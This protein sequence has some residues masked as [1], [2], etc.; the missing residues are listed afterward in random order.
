MESVCIIGGGKRLARLSDWLDQPD[1]FEAVTAFLR[2]RG[3]IRSTRVLLAV[4]AASSVLAP[5][6][7]IVPGARHVTVGSAVVIGVV[8]ASLSCVMTWFWLTR[9]PTRRQSLIAASMATVCIVAWSLAQPSAALAALT[10]AAVP[11]TSGYIAFFHSTR[12]L[13]LN[14]AA[15]QVASAV[16]AY[17]LATDVDIKTAIAALWLLWLI[18]MVAPFTVRGLSEAMSKYATRA[19]EDPLTGLLNRRG[20][21]D[22]VERLLIGG[23][24]GGQNYLVML[25][26]DLDDFKR[27]NDTYGHAAGD[28]VLLRVADILRKHAPVDAAICRAGGEEFLLAATSRTGD[29]AFT[30]PLCRAIAALAGNVTA[31]IGVTVVHGQD[32]HAAPR[33]ADLVLELIGAADS[34]MYAAKRSGGNRVVIGAR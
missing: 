34:A 13:A 26:V 9:W 22:V 12:A 28:R 30:T 16:A 24:A 27:I 33:P 18:N 20:F 21:L 19:D 32:V 5:L 7:L 6:A 1:Q 17:R 29:A 31:S 11:I 3:L 25:M 14:I 8:G 23:M 15:G 10:C 2:H 4:V